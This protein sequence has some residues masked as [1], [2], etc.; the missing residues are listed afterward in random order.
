MYMLHTSC[1][2]SSMALSMITLGTV[3][4]FTVFWNNYLIKACILVR[5]NMVVFG[6]SITSSCRSFVSVSLSI[7]NCGTSLIIKF[8][9]CLQKILHLCSHNL[10]LKLKNLLLLTIAIVCIVHTGLSFFVNAS[11]RRSRLESSWTSCTSVI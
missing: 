6:G 10:P 4:Y 8:T 3:F 9:L 7:N 1:E 5:V 11:N 2:E